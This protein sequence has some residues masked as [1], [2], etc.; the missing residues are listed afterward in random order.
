MI[1]FLIDVLPSDAANP[2]FSPLV[3][4]INGQLDYSDVSTS[5]VTVSNFDL[6]A[7]IAPAI[8]NGSF[9]RYKSVFLSKILH[10]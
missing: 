10:F 3:D 5:N 7:L 2:A 1:G 6:G 8:Q 9:F 4:A